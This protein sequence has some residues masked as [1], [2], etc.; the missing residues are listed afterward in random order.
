MLRELG[1]PEVSEVQVGRGIVRLEG[2]D[3]SSKARLLSG[4]HALLSGIVEVCH[5]DA[6][7]PYGDVPAVC[8]DRV[9]EVLV[10]TAD[11]SAGGLAV[12]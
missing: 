1:D 3:P 6:V 10:V 8:N 11:N 4:V 9:E 7:D 2:N 5:L 12:V